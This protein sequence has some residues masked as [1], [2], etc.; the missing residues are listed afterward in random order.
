MVSYQLSVTL[1]LMLHTGHNQCA[2]IGDL[3]M[4]SMMPLIGQLNK[5][6]VGWVALAKVVYLLSAKGIDSC[7]H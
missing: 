4:A 1:P 3:V 5:S 2:F 6:I 7:Q